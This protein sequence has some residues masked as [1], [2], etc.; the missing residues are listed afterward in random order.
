MN[1]ERL[2]RAEELFDAVCD[3][4]RAERDAVLERECAG[5]AELRGQV[6]RLLARDA[7][8]HALDRPVLELDRS[9]ADAPLPDRIGRYAVLRVLGEGGMG[10]V[11][12]A[13]QDEPRRSVALKVMRAAASS[14]EHFARFRRE[15]RVLGALQHPGIAQV[16]EAGTGELVVRGTVVGEVPFLA[17]ELV[18]GEP[19]TRACERAALSIEGRLELFARIADAVAHAHA[20][21]VVHRDLKPGN[22]LVV[23]TTTTASGVRDHAGAALAPKVLDFGIA[24]LVESEGEATLST[25]TGQVLGT[26]AYMSPEQARGDGSLV[27]ARADVWAL[28]VILYEL[29]AGRRPLE[30]D[31]LPLA[32]ASRRIQEDEPRPL[33]ALDAQLA[34]DLET[35]VGKALEKDPSR[36]YVDAAALAAD[37]RRHLAHEPIAAR[38]PSAIY[39]ASKFARRNKALVLGS[40]AAL[41][42][43]IGGLGYGLFQAQ[44]QRDEAELATDFL[45]TMLRAP[46]PMK[47]GA[48]ITMART[49]QMAV[50]DLRAR[51]AEKPLLLARLS[52]ELGQT[53]VRDDRALA[54]SLFEDA[55]RL[56]TQELGAEHPDT[57]QAR[58][59]VALIETLEHQ[60]EAVASKA[61]SEELAAV[62]KA[63][64]EIAPEDPRTTL[65]TRAR[66]ATLLVEQGKPD[67]A[68]TLFRTILADL[69]K[70]GLAGTPD[71]L[72]V[73]VGLS[74]ALLELGKKDECE[75]VARKAFVGL[76]SV[77]GREHPSVV[78]AANV[79][80]IV[81]SDLGKFDEAETLV[82]ENLAIH[83]RLLGPDDATTLNSL[84]TLASIESERGNYDRAR[85]LFKDLLASTERAS[86]PDSPDMLVTLNNAA[87]V[88]LRSGHADAAEPLFRTARERAERSLGRDHWYTWAFATAQGAALTEMG[89]P[90]DA[91][92]VLLEAH[93]ENERLLGPTD[94]RTKRVATLLAKLYTKLQR[95]DDAKA[96]QER[97][98]AK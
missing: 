18:R 75:R 88:E 28:G 74:H 92:R 51:F 19:L 1:H 46:D 5:D 32:T 33:G 36:R 60:G 76:L 61:A 77:R 80:G 17:M 26:L 94:E 47:G 59:A 96:W 78:D 25:K 12:E 2:R 63:Q 52:F 15:A 95:A 93:A 64:A 16:F 11:Y 86:G 44:K 53:L 34:G 73:Q 48:G 81:L 22:V 43:L 13:L 3:L 30:L 72:D 10:S 91:E 31:G 83:Q 27:D 56:R 70:Q 71:E 14:K 97:A 37:V 90:E 62:E 21:G 38:P 66:R 67:E 58:S 7:D 39:V 41:V 84:T 65:V 49:V 42:A 87:Q 57:L 9:A 6:E 50:P 54:R 23:E 40:A 8:A 45:I 29:L 85:E 4:S 24:R 82:R 98:D 69:A 35:I 68:E 79:L 55:V 20:Q 89:R